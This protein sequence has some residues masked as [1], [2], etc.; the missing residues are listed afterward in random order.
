MLSVATPLPAD[1]SV[2]L[3]YEEFCFVR[4]SCPK[5]IGQSV[6]RLYTVVNCSLGPERLTLDPN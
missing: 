6:L 2:Y 3:Q 5:Y 1:I 4:V